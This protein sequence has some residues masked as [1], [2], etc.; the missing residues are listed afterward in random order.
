MHDTGCLGLVYWVVP[1]SCSNQ[2]ISCIELGLVTFFIYDIIHVSMP[3]SQ[4]IPPSPSPRVQKTVL[5][6]CVSFALSHT[7]LSFL[8]KCY[9]NSTAAAKSLQSCPTLCDPIDCSLPGC[10]I[11]GDFQAR[12]LEWFAIAFS[13]K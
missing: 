5:Y 7:G 2:P 4:I 10:S 1:I 11:H 8:K 13:T 9:P 12:V 6:I 3:F